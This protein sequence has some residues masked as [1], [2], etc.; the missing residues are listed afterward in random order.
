MNNEVAQ[1]IIVGCVVAVSTSFVAYMLAAGISETRK[2]NAGR[3]VFTDLHETTKRI[4]DQIVDAKFRNI[5]R[6]QD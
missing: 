2:N 5:I 1:K 3:K 4:D 6:D